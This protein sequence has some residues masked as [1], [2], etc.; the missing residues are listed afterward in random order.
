MLCAELL[1]QGL[2]IPFGSAL[3]ADRQ[4][5]ESQQLAKDVLSAPN[6]RRRA[7]GDQH[8]TYDFPPVLVATNSDE[9][10]SLPAPA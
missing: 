3:D 9:G 10:A 5:L 7:R 1:A 6:P 4:I 2:P 8:R